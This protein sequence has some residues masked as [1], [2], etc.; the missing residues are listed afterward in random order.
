MGAAVAHDI[1]ASCWQRYLFALAHECAVGCVDGERACCGGD[2]SAAEREGC[3][4][5]AWCVYAVHHVYRGVDVVLGLGGEQ[6]QGIVAIDL[7]DNHFIAGEHIVAVVL[8]G[9]FVLALVDGCVA[10]AIIPGLFTIVGAC[11]KVVFVV[12]RPSVF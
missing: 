10:I 6:F 1:H 5:A 2:C 11:Y 7:I 3:C 9:A 4:L 12:A 8:V